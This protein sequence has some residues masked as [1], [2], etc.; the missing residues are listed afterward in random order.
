[1]RLSSV[2]IRASLLLICVLVFSAASRAQFRASIQGTV[3][4]PKGAAVAGA[5][6]TVTN[7]DTTIQRETTT[8]DQGFYRVNE[9]PPGTY[10][11]SVEAAG[12][13]Q[14]VLKNII[15]EAEQPRGLDVTME[16]GAVVESVTVSAGETG[17]QTENASITNT[18]TSQ[19]VLTLPQ[20]GRDPYELLRLTPGVFGDAARQGNGNSFALPQQVGPGGSNSEIFQTEN[21]VQISSNGQRVTANTYTLDGVSV[22]SLSNGGAA[23]ITPNQESVQEIVVTSATFNAE[24]GRNS[25][26]QVQVISKGGTNNF[27]GSGLIKF[28][29]KGLNAFNKFYGPTTG[30]LP[31]L[32]CEGGAF[33]IVASHCPT[34]NDQKYRDFGGSFGG[35][36]LKDKLFFFF[37]YEGLRQSNTITKRDVKL[38]TPAFEQ[39]VIQVNPNSLAAKVFKTPGV[40]AR[41]STTTKQVD[42]CSLVTNPSDPNFR[43]LGQWYT[44]GNTPR[45]G[46]AVG[47]GPDGIPDWGIFDLRVP[48]SSTGDQFNG[49]L[50]YTKGLNQFFF[51]TYSVSLNNLNGA[52][53]PIEDLTL[54]PNNRVATV[55]WTRTINSRFL[56]EA[57]FNFTRFSFNQLPPSGLTDYGIPQVRLFDF[58]AGGLGDVGT[59]LG[60]PAAGTTPGKLAENT[61]AFKDTV[62]WIRGNQGFKFGV[63]VTKEQNNDNES[64][65]E[66]PNYQFRGLLN[67]ANDACCFAESVAVNPLTGANPDGQRYFRSAIYALFVQDDWK[68]RPN[69]TINLGLRWE[70]FPPI[71]ET[72][73]RL[74]NYIFGTQGFINGSVQKVTQLYNSNKTD[75]GPRLGFAYSPNVWGHKTVL[76]GGFGILYDRPFET[77]FSNVRQNTPFFAQPLLCCFFDPGPIVGPPPG[78]NIQYALGSSSLANSYPANKNLAFGVAPD[79]ALCG[80]A[81]CTTATKVDIFG[82][83]PNEPTPYVYVY[84]LQTQLEPVNKLQ[85]TVGYQGSRSRKLARTID[86]NRFRPGDTFDPC[87]PPV[88]GK[89]CGNVDEVQSASPDGVPCGPSN[90]ACPAPIIVGNNRFG[91]VFVPLPDV[92]ASFDAGIFQVSRRFSRGLTL[93]SVYTYSHSIDTSSYEIGFQQSDP[94]NQLINKGSSDYDVRHHWQLSGY[95]EVPFLRSRHDLLGRAL[96]GW[97]LGGILDKHSGFPFSALIGSCDPNNDRNGDGTCPDL[98]AAYFGGAIQNPSKKQ[99]I[100]GIFPNPKTEFDVTTR[101]PGCRCR[102]IFTG[103]G[104]TDVDLSFGK[105]FSFPSSRAL[106]EAAQLEFRANF[107][108][109]FNILNLQPLA[110]ATAPT[111]IINTGSFGRPSDGLSGRVIEFQLRLSF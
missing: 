59:L 74:S 28:N 72:Q 68:I 99:W 2:F 52:N 33:T 65:F 111:D 26:A 40:A 101:G 6:V 4:D 34:R 44:A 39:Y 88:V 21:Q 43:Q 9:L 70:Y 92:N 41:I 83:L 73:N 36:I 49:R 8:S 16:V 1:M 38:E 66:R 3:L 30:T 105:I 91:R 64:G 55:G 63:E 76:R 57:R 37:S 94:F 13:K 103:P 67:F 82:A 106:G 69:L 56:N 79:G 32:T 58:D 50:D 51:S 31:T 107:F 100:N 95:W 48:N 25:G 24:Q 81:A 47:N 14:E 75:F 102:N 97:T 29:D 19:E 5:K 42:C 15:I 90:P 11:V 109:A 61:F 104:Y 54:A 78:S 35:P 20:F 46:Q 7:Q 84:S 71:T 18:I 62:N 89:T 27:H 110:P 23:V 60:I 17:L 93:S 53:R 85:V 22:D 10:T 12:F 98:P 96:G 87:N 108:N 45:M 86:L 77:L 80:N